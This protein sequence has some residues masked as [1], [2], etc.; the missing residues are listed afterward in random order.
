MATR[1]SATKCR[2]G[3]Y[4]RI[5]TQDQKTLSMQLWQMRRYV[6]DRGWSVAFE[7]QDVGSGAKDRPRREEVMKA[8][9]KREIDSTTSYRP[10]LTEISGL[11]TSSVAVCRLG[12]KLQKPFT[13]TTPYHAFFYSFC[14]HTLRSIDFRR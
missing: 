6:K 11:D 7:I 3:L 5:S 13:I 9:R 10:T 1:H 14:C 8:A 2:V 12:K 4:A